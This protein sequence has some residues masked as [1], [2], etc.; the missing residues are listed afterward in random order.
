MHIADRSLVAPAPVFVIAEAGVNHN[1]KLDLAVELVRA[2]A[3]AGADA[4]KFQTFKAEHLVARG[5]AMAEYQQQNTGLAGDQLAMLRALELS[6]D[7]HRTVFAEARRAGICAFSSPFDPVS[8]RFL[9][10]LGVPCFKLGSGELTNLA[11]L[12]EVG[13]YGRPV[14]VSTGMATLAEVDLAVA[15]L[16][17]GGCTDLAI[18]HCVSTYP[19]PCAAINLR[20]MHTLAQAY[21]HY[22]VGYSDHTLGDEVV[23]AAVALG[24]RI[25]EKHFTLDRNLP[26]PDHRSSLEPAEL[27]TMV[28]RIRRVEEAIGSGR[29]RPAAVEQATREVVRKWLVATTDLEPGHVIAA[30]DLVA[31]RAA[32]DN[33][34]SPD[35]LD[36]VVGMRLHN[37]LPCDAP[38][39]WAHLRER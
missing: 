20:A 29:K 38:L 25:I 10:A 5:T 19:A 17:A 31:K 11:L 26:G 8:A 33:A 12:R 24:A 6:E 15:A 23:L 21:P 1:G 3:Q 30:G 7:D 22:P 9:D 34:V 37:I 39:T 2:A 14:I 28:Q 27:A 36:N 32:G 4:V 35:L 13:R 16:E 18:L